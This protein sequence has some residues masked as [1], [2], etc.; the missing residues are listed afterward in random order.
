MSNNTRY[1]IIEVKKGL[2]KGQT[3]NA[4]RYNTAAGIEYHVM[5]DGKKYYL[6]QQHVLVTG[7]R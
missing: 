6:K 5:V 7:V 4:E 3:L 2:F 1:V